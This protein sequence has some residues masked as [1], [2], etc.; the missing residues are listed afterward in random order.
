M[1]ARSTVTEVSIAC[2]GLV[3][4]GD[5]LGQARVGG[6][7]AD[8]VAVCRLRARLWSR[9]PFGGRLGK[10]DGRGFFGTK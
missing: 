7:G 9:R 6:V 3:D 4:A 8:Q 2:A 5:A 10:E 1:S